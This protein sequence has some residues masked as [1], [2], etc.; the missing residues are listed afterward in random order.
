MS[1]REN[2]KS[3]TAKELEVLNK[4]L[5]E[6]KIR[7]NETA[8][9][10]KRAVADY[11]N[12]EK[13]VGQE[14]AMDILLANAILLNKLLPV[15]DN[16]EQVV[17]CAPEEEKTSSWFRGIEMV[18]RQFQ[19]I[20]K[21]EGLTEIRGAGAEFNPEFHEAVDTEP[22]KDNQVIKVVT[23]GYKFGERVLRPARVVVGKEE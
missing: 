23:K 5:K 4:E 18:L 12:L 14:K 9:L 7:L 21:Q 3:D 8:D 10:Y 11:Q 22:G 19:D 2:R 15:V 6:V 16:M 17:N 20:L 13:R 1:K